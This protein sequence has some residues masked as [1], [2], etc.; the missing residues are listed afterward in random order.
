MQPEK[1]YQMKE[2]FEIMPQKGKV[3]WIGIRRVKRGEVENIMEVKVLVESGLEGDHY[4]GKSG[5]RQVTLIQSE[6]I[7][8]VSS[9]MKKEVDPVL[10]R[11]NIVV[12]GINLLAF[13]DK[14]FSIGEEVVFEVTGL[15]H[16]CSRMETNLGAGGYNAMRGHGGITTRVINGGIIKIG[17]EV[18][19]RSEE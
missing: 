17:D 18:E 3:E 10:L 4:S 8:T 9:I 2:L 1:T 13:K 14:Q 16:P 12:S 15:C 5:N 7:A 6:H 11:R 19:F